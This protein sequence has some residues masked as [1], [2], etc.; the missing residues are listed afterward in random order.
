VKTDE[1][2]NPSKNA[3][4]PDAPPE[5][6]RYAGVLE[7]C[8]RAGFVLLVMSFVLYMLGIPKPVIALDQLPQYW[9][10]PVDEFV[11]A[12]HTPTGWAWLAM[13]GHGDTLNLV[14]IALLA[15]ASAFSS[16]A[17]LP[18]FGRRG[19]YALLAITLLQLIVVVASASNLLPGR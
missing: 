16:L 3:P 6:P 11:R 4:S 17:V 14:G 18:V 12:T 19:E 10:L 9:G 7:A 5:Q 13:I 15:S 1:K 2:P 8:V